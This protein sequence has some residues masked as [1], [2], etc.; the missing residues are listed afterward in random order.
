MDWSAPHDLI[1]NKNNNQYKWSHMSF[2]AS[3][4]NNQQ[5]LGKKLTPPRCPMPP[6]FKQKNEMYVTQNVW[7]RRWKVEMAGA[8]RKVEMA[9]RYDICG[10]L[11]I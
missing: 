9:G 10:P 7:W 1:D 3:T 8:R 6:S 2:P 11:W 4:W 5:R